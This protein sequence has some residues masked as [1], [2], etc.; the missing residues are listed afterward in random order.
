MHSRSQW[1]WRQ[2]ELGGARLLGM[3]YQTWG[4]LLFASASHLFTHTSP[5]AKL[6][7]SIYLFFSDFCSFGSARLG[8][9]ASG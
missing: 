7:S 3:F 9:A 1:T 2:Q 4:A 5:L 8:P 6:S